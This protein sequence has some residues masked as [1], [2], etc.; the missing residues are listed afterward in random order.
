MRKA[1]LLLALSAA[2]VGDGTKEIDG[3][4]APVRIEAGGAPIDVSGGHAAPCVADLDGDGAFLW[5]GRSPWGAR[6][7]FYRNA[8]TNDAPRFGGYVCVHG[9]GEEA[10]VPAG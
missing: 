7:R 1:A 3:L 4:E 10:R 9:G 6:I 2:A 8:G 5:E